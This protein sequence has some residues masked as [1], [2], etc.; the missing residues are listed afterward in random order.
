MH[1]NREKDD[2]LTY[3][4]HHPVLNEYCLHDLAGVDSRLSKLFTDETTP[5]AI[6]AEPQWQQDASALSSGPASPAKAD[7]STSLKQTLQSETEKVEQKI[8]AFKEMAQ[9]VQGPDET[10]SEP[11]NRALLE[12]S[13]Q[14]SAIRDYA[15]SQQ[16][17]VEKLQNGYDW[18]I[19]RQFALRIIRCVDN[20]EQRVDNQ[21]DESDAAEQL[22]DIRDE[23][24]FALESSGIEQFMPE[25]DSPYSGQERTAEAVKEK[26][27]CTDPE[28]V[29]KIAAVVKPGYQ[30]VIDEDNA[31]VVRTARVRLYG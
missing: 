12:M 29:G 18:N 19:I 11:M 17:R 24:L 16:D 21:K 5:S 3:K 1:G 4:R 8:D 23:L 13:A 31:K 10:Q 25:L 22:T 2:S 27:S 7:A 30:Y 28:R 9:S 14:I 20:L 15:A 6:V 26:E